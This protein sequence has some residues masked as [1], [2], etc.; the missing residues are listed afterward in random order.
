L[1]GLYKTRDLLNGINR[2][3][4]RRHYE[5]ALILLE[6]LIIRLQRV[7]RKLEEWQKPK[8]EGEA[9]PKQ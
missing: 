9:R 8:N 2:Q 1:S 7:K 5:E 4:E 3:L 6:L